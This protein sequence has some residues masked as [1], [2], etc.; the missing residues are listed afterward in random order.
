MHQHH[1]GNTEFRVV[2]KATVE[3]WYEPHESVQTVTFIN[4]D[5]TN[6]AFI[7]LH[8]NIDGT[9]DGSNSG[10]AGIKVK[11]DGGQVI[12]SQIE[13]FDER[14]ARYK[15]VCELRA[16]CF[17]RRASAAA[18]DVECFAVLNLGVG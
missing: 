4:Q 14:L 10:Q 17:V 9:V 12:F 15:K 5:S 11:K 6:D 3:Q 8:S 1:L 16:P 2:A 13:T 18:A 7:G